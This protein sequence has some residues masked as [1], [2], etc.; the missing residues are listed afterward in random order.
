M[1]RLGMD[2]LVFFNSAHNLMMFIL[3]V[4]Y[5][6]LV[7]LSFIDQVLVDILTRPTDSFP[8]AFMKTLLWPLFLRIPQI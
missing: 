4:Y 5:I 3:I 1:R 8:V 2:G 6:L 7:L